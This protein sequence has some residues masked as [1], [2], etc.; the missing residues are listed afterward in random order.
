MAVDWKLVSAGGGVK[1]MA[2][3]CT[4][5]TCTSYQLS[6]LLRVIYEPTCVNE[7]RVYLL[8]TFLAREGEQYMNLYV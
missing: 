2:M 6:L 5:C 7:S 3:F 1:N 4:L 8:F